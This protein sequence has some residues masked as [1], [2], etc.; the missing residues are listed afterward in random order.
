MGS[1]RA[2]HGL[3]MTKRFGDRTRVTIIPKRG[4]MPAGTLA[5]ILSHQ[6]TGLGRAGLQALIDKYGK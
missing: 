2:N 6:Q 5:A 1:S 3:T 4:D